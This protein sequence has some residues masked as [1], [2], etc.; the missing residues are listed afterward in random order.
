M[1]Q[2]VNLDPTFWTDAHS[3]CRRCAAVRRSRRW[4]AAASLD[5]ESSSM[6]ELLQ[7]DLF[8]PLDERILELSISGS[9]SSSFVPALHGYA[10]RRRT[11]RCSRPRCMPWHARVKVPEGWA[12]ISVWRR[13]VWRVIYRVYTH[14][15]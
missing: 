14:S 4:P 3:V 13:L 10:E 11:C 1:R 8:L 2:S 6:E 7:P 5:G 9:S 12:A 15:L